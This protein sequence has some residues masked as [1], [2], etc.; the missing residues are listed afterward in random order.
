MTTDLTCIVCP[1]GCQLTIDENKQVS[2][3][4]CKRGISYAHKELTNP[5][6]TITSTVRINGGLYRRIPVKTSDEIAKEDIFKVMTLLDEVVLEAP[7]ERHQVVLHNILGT[8]VDII[9][10]RSMKK[11]LQ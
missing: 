4:M 9:T 3:N 6:R 8:S 10:T 1:I 11:V 5:T 2:G 7:V